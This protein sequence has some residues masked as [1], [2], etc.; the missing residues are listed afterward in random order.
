MSYYLRLVV[1]GYIYQRQKWGGVSRV[2]NEILPL[3]CDLDPSATIDIPLLGKPIQALPQ[4]ERI[5]HRKMVSFD[6]YL[7][8]GRVWWP[9]Q[10]YQ[11][12]LA[13]T[14]IR[15]GSRNKIWHSTYYTR[16]AAWRG[17]RV[18]TVHDLIHEKYK[19]YYPGLRWDMARNEM[20]RCIE[21]ADLAICVSESTSA[22]LQEVYG[23]PTSKIQVIPNGHS[24]VF[25]SDARRPRGLDFPFL[26]NVGGRFG[27]PAFVYKGTR[28]LLEA[29]RKWH[30]RGKHKLLLVSGHWSRE[31]QRIVSEMGLT[32]NVRLLSNI[33]DRELAWLYRHA[34]AYV[35]PSLHEG[36]GI[37]VIE[38]MANRCPVVA[39]NIPSTNEIAGRVPVYFEAQNGEELGTAL[40]IGCSIERDAER[41]TEGLRIASGFSWHKAA[42][43]TIAA[44][45]TLL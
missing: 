7:W 9:V 40:D 11:R 19:Q 13:L 36:F 44:Y 31:E 12:E 39:S 28:T 23:T 22:D 24:A 32:A 2:F 37:P 43:A 15:S 42:K 41:I 21:E 10:R 26:L 14:P 8:P 27:H 18:V 38:A 5:T 3:I 34:S 35:H 4:H 29:F 45:R 6:D 25:G 1:D 30:K 20:R 16:C 17:P 33:D